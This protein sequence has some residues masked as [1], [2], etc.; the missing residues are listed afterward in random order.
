MKL[1][2]NQYLDGLSIAWAVIEYIGDTE[3]I[4]CKTLFATH[5]MS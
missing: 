3:E 5:T 4:G 1:K 2:G